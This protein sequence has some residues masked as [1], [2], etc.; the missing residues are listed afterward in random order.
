MSIRILH[1]VE[2]AAPQAAV[3]AAFVKL[4]DWPRWFPALTK[5][6]RE[7][8]GA[9]TTD[10]RFTLCLSFRGHGADV[11]VKVV[12]HDPPRRVRWVGR[13]LGVTGD[14]AFFTEVIS[15]MRT[16][17]VS[18]ETF[19]GLPVRFIPKE[20]FGELEDATRLGLG[21]FAALVLT[22]I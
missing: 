10:E 5:L 17:F 20:I 18:E 13:N 21:R 6:K 4:E 8:L 15:P 16:R 22:T 1:A 12:E 19:S 14:H 3:W 2:I 7:A 11:G 9:F